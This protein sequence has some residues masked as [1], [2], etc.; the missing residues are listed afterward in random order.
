M[1]WAQDFEFT[2]GVVTTTDVYAGVTAVLWAGRT[3]LGD[4]F[5]IMPVPSSSLFKT[6]G[7]ITSNGKGGYVAEEIINGTATTPYLASLGLEGLPENPQ[8]GSNGEWN[9]LSLLYANG[10][11]DGFFGQNYNT[12]QVGIVTPD[13]LPF[14]DASLP[15]AIQSAHDNP[16]QV[17]SGGPWNTVYNGDVPF[18]AT[19]YWLANVDPTW[20][21]PP[22]KPVLQPTQAPLP[23]TAFAAYGR[24]N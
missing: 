9:F 7:D 24:S 22:K 12:A 10:L 17:A 8:H 14:H 11:I 5:K 13:T 15:Y 3:Y 21:Q 6:L 23:T 1:I 16:T 4:S 18:H 20:S 19:V 2:P